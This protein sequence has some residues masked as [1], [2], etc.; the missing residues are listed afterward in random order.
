MNR[1][2]FIRT[3]TGA[4]L[5]VDN[6]VR[7]YALN[8]VFINETTPVIGG[9]AS[10]SEAADTLTGAAA[11]TVSASAELH[12]AETS[13]SASA[14]VLVTASAE[15]LEGTDTVEASGEAAGGANSGGGGGGRGRHRY[16]RPMWLQREE[17]N[18]PLPPKPAA[19]ARKRA[20]RE[21]K[22]IAH[23]FGAT[24]AKATTAEVIDFLLAEARFHEFVA[25]QA[26]RRRIE[27]LIERAI[28]EARNDDE[29]TALML[30]VG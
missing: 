9:T 23:D 13:L 14:S 15:I 3:A 16:R 5:V 8:G 25:E 6:K 4:L 12:E 22:E 1:Q 20:E 17:E 27:A 26:N 2:Y 28:R 30:L 19:V 29:E 10:I 21:I 18:E 11:V 7:Q 24:Q